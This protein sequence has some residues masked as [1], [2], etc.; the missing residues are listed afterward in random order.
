MSREGGVKEERR[1]V[2]NGQGEEGE[3][4]TQKKMEKKNMRIFNGIER[5][6]KALWRRDDFFY[7]YFFIFIFFGLRF[8]P[9]NPTH[10]LFSF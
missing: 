1:G 5:V 9:V 7:F 6:S 4:E 2:G 10:F 3:A 8:L